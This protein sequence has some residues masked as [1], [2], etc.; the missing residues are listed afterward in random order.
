MSCNFAREQVD[1]DILTS[2]FNV[3]ILRDSQFP[4]LMGYRCTGW[5]IV[6]IHGQ[7]VFQ[8]LYDRLDLDL[9]VGHTQV[10]SPLCSRLELDPFVVWSAR[11]ETELVPRVFLL[12]IY[13]VCTRVRPQVMAGVG[14]ETTYVRGIISTIYGTTASTV[15]TVQWTLCNLKYMY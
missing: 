1:S 6:N 3:E 12:F 14:R 7:D 13:K 8:S 5:G 10:Y 2:I 9:G 15:L 4:S 11:S